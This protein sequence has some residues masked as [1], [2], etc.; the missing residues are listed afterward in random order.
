MKIIVLITLIFL[1]GPTAFSQVVPTGLINE[2]VVAVPDKNVNGTSKIYNVSEV[3]QQ[4]EF[5]GGMNKFREYIASSFN[6][7]PDEGLNGRMLITFC[8]EIDGSITDHG[9][10]LGQQNLFL[11]INMTVLVGAIHNL[12]VFC[13]GY[14]EIVDDVLDEL[15][16]FG[17]RCTYFFHFLF[18]WL[19]FVVKD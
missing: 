2:N 8:V 16:E 11:L 5:P 4:A 7:P 18:S 15:F 1:V 13:R 12:L 17:G 14:L 9:L 3:E 19:E 6:M 10:E